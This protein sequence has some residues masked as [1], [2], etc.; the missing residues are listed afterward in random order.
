MANNVTAGTL[1]II[2][3]PVG[4]NQPNAWADVCSI[5][6]LLK[7]AGE[8]V[9]VDGK[10][11]EKSQATLVSFQKRRLTTAPTGA[12]PGGRVQNVLTVDSP[13]LELLAYE[14]GV[15][16][17]IAGEKGIK[18]LTTMH[19]WLVSNKVQYQK[20]AETGGGNRAV[21]GLFSNR[22][23]GIQTMGTKRSLECSPIL[24]DC[25]TYVNMMLA[26]YFDGN[27]HGKYAAGLKDTGGATAGTEHIGKSRW[28]M[29]LVNRDKRNFHKTTDQIVASAS[30]GPGK[31]YHLEVGNTRN[32]VAGFVT[33]MALMY[34]DTVYECT[35]KP[36][37]NGSA[38]IKRPLSEFM[39]NKSAS[40]IYLFAEA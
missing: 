17:P 39:A 29:R 20:G 11:G 4:L 25:T 6:Q 10:W 30:E 38:C 32:G 27:L 35:P 13:V 26:L 16:L 14:A 2:Q 12:F 36:I 18:G 24:L 40:I 8:S 19:D 31:L 15:L 28:G 33:H 34:G 23:L 37:L 1:R 21:W 5:Q 22:T 3:Q 9:R 7:A